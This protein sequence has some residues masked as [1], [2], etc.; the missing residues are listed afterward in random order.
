VDADVDVECVRGWCTFINMYSVECCASDPVMPPSFFYKF[1]S[2]FSISVSI[3]KLLITSKHK[4]H[5]IHL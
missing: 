3:V 5:F 2:F 4:L 1:G